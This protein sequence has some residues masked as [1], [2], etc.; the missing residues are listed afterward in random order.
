[1]G[2]INSKNLLDHYRLK[3][4]IIDNCRIN[5]TYICQLQ[6]PIKIYKN[7]HQNESPIIYL[8][9]HDEFFQ[10]LIWNVSVGFLVWSNE[11]F[12]LVGSHRITE[13]I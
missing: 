5:E 10:I 6:V 9:T 4:N 13:I 12:D 8:S 1:M 7:Y 3:M 2:M 11:K